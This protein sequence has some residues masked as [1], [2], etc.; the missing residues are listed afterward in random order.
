VAKYTDDDFDPEPAVGKYTDDDFDRVTAEE[1]PPPPP[2]APLPPTAVSIARDALQQTPLNIAITGL[3]LGMAAPPMIKAAVEGITNLGRKAAEVGPP[4]SAREALDL[5][6]AAGGGYASGVKPG[7]KQFVGGYAAGVADLATRAGMEG[8]ARG[9][10]LSATSHLTSAAQDLKKTGVPQQ[11]EDVHS[12]TQFG[13]FIG[14]QAG[15][16][17]L[18]AAQSLAIG[19]LTRGRSLPASLAAQ[20]GSATLMEYGQIAQEANEKLG[21]GKVPFT[22]MAKGA[23][24][25]GALE[26]LGMLPELTLLRGGKGALR[27]AGAVLV[28]P[29]LEGITEAGQTYAEATPL[30]GTAAEKSPAQL[31][32][33]ARQAA[34][35]GFVASGPSTAVAAGLGKVKGVAQRE[36]ARPELLKQAREL[37]IPEPEKLK[38]SRLSEQVA[39][40]REQQYAETLEQHGLEEQDLVA[41]AAE[42]LRHLESLPERTP[43]Q[44]GVRQAL[45][46]ATGDPRKIAAIPGYAELVGQDVAVTTKRRE[47]VK[48]RVQA[49]DLLHVTEQDL[50]E[51]QSRIDAFE[52]FTAQAHDAAQAQLLRNELSAQQELL[53]VAEN[54]APELGEARRAVPPMAGGAMRERELPLR[55]AQRPVS[56]LTGPTARAQGERQLER[57]QEAEGLRELNPANHELPLGLPAPIE[58]AANEH[59]TAAVDQG[60][61][62][63]ATSPLNE[64]PIPTPERQKAGRYAKGLVKVQGMAISIEHPQGSTRYGVTKTGEEWQ[65]ELKDHYGYF[66][67]GKGKDGDQLDVFIGPRPISH[68]VFVVN[69]VDPSTGKFDEHKVMLGYGSVAEAEAAYQRNYQEGWQGLKSVTPMSMKEFKAWKAKSRHVAEVTNDQTYQP[70]IPSSEPQGPAAVEAGLVPAPSR[71]AARPSRDVQAPAGEKAA[72]VVATQPAATGKVAAAPSRP[73]KGAPA[74]PVASTRRGYNGV[75]Y[76]V[77]PEGKTKEAAEGL[78]VLAIAAEREGDVFRLALTDSRVKAAQAHPEV[79]TL[80]DKG[81]YG[82]D[83]VDVKD[84]STGKSLY[85][86]KV[87]QPRHA[88]AAKPHPGGLTE[89]TAKEIAKRHGLDRVPF[90]FID[91]PNFRNEQKRLIQGRVLNGEVLVN[92]AAIPDAQRLEEV[93]LEEGAHH[94][95]GSE[96]GRALLNKFVRDRLTL[97]ALQALQ[98]DYPRN[99]E[100]ETTEDYFQRIADEHIAQQ[101]E[102]QTPQWKVLVQVVKEFLARTGLVDLSDATASQAVLRAVRHESDSLAAGRGARHALVSTKAK[103]YQNIKYPEFSDLASGKRVKEISDKNMMF[104]SVRPLS[105]KTFVVVADGKG[106]NKVSPLA[107]ISQTKHAASLRGQ[108]GDIISHPE[109]FKNYP[110]LAK[111]PTLIF[112]DHKLPAHEWFGG[113]AEDVSLEADMRAASGKT[114]R[115]TGVEITAGSMKAALEALRHELTH[116]I[117]SDEGLPQGASR[118][119]MAQRKELQ[120]FGYQTDVKPE[121]EER[122]RSARAGEAYHRETGEIYARAVEKRGALSQEEL[123]HH[124]FFEDLDVPVSEEITLEPPPQYVARRTGKSLQQPVLQGDVGQNG[125]K[126]PR[127]ARHALAPRLVPEGVSAQ[128]DHLRSSALLAGEEAQKL[129]AEGKGYAAKNAAIRANQLLSDARREAARARFAVAPDEGQLQLPPSAPS[130]EDVRRGQA[131]FYRGVPEG[132]PDVPG[133]VT[134]AT[135]DKSFAETFH[136]G[137]AGTGKATVREVPVSGKN[138]WDFRDPHHLAAIAAPVEDRALLV[139]GDWGAVERNLELI[140]VAGYDGFTE[141]ES[142]ALN[143]GI[144]NFRK[145]ERPGEMA[146]TWDAESAIDNPLPPPEP[147]GGLT[148]SQ[149]AAKRRAEEA[150]TANARLALAPERQAKLDEVAAFQVRPIGELQAM[151]PEQLDRLHDYLTSREAAGTL[152]RGEGPVSAGRFALAKFNYAA[153]PKLNIDAATNDD[154]EFKTPKD[155]AAFNKLIKSHLA[156]AKGAKRD[157]S[158]IVQNW[159]N[160]FG[161]TTKA[162]QLK[163][164]LPDGVWLGGAEDTLHDFIAGNQRHGLDDLMRAGGIRAWMTPSEASFQIGASLTAEQRHQIAKVISEQGATA[165]KA[166]NFRMF[167][168]VIDPADKKVNGMKFLEDI[169][170]EYFPASAEA[171]LTHVDELVNAVFSGGSVARY[172]SLLAPYVR[173]WGSDEEGRFALAPEGPLETLT[174]EETAQRFGP[175]MDALLAQDRET[176]EQFIGEL[177]DVSAGNLLHNVNNKITAYARRAAPDLRTAMDQAR[178]A[179]ELL[180]D[181]L[182][183]QGRFALAPTYHSRLQRAVEG[184]KSEKISL[185]ELTSKTLVNVDAEERKWSGFDEWVTEQRRQDKRSVTKSEVL[186]F[187]RENDVR[188]EEKVLTNQGSQ[189]TSLRDAARDA[190]AE[191][192]RADNDALR[193]EDPSIPDVFVDPGDFSEAEVDAFLA[194]HGTE[195]ENEYEVSET[196]AKFASYQLPGGENYRELLLTLPKKESDQ[197]TSLAQELRAAEQKKQAILGAHPTIIDRPNAAIEA[198]NDIRDQIG[199]IQQH[200][201]DENKTGEVFISSHF[202]EPNILAHVRFNERTDT[203]GKRVLFLEELQSDWAQTGRKKGFRDERATRQ[204]SE[205]SREELLEL[206]QQNDRNGAYTDEATAAEDL[207]PMTK[208]DALAVF[209]EFQD[210]DPTI[211]AGYFLRTRFSADGVPTAPFVQSTEKWAGLALRRMV[212]WAA[213]HG[214]ERLAWTTG[215]QQAERYDL[216][217]V[218]DDVSWSDVPRGRAVDMKLRGK[219]VVGV[220]I[221]AHGKIVEGVSEAR[222]LVGRSIDEVVGKDIAAKIMAKDIGRLGVN[223]LKVGGEGMKGFYDLVLPKLAAKIGK[224]WGARVGEAKITQGPKED[225]FLEVRIRSAART[226]GELQVAVGDG[227]FYSTSVDRIQMELGYGDQPIVVSAARRILDEGGGT[228]IKIPNPNYQARTTTTIH[229]LDLP[230]TMRESALREGVA[231][232]ALAPEDSSPA[233]LDS[234]DWLTRAEGFRLP[235]AREA[236]ATAPPD[237]TPPQRQAL[238]TE[239]LLRGLAAEGSWLGGALKGVLPSALSPAHLQAAEYVGTKLG[240]R[241]HTAEQR[242]PV[243]EP[244]WQ[245]FTKLGVDKEGPLEEN[246]GIQF[247]SALSSPA[248]RFTVP[249]RL[250][251]AATTIQRQFEQAVKRVIEVE[252]LAFQAEDGT[253]VVRERY[254]PGMYTKESK[255]AFNQAMAEHV[256]AAR[257]ESP[258][259]ELADLNSWSAEERAELKARVEELLASG[260]GRQDDAAFARAF[261]RRPLEGKKSFLKE[262]VFDDIMTAVDFGLRPFSNNPV[263]LVAAKLHELDQFVLGRTIR[264]EKG[265]FVSSFKTA[266]APSG[267]RVPLDPAFTVIGPPQDGRPV[268]GHYYVPNALADV[269]DNFMSPT[270]Y[271][272]ANPFISKSYQVYMKAGARL[273]SSQL[274]VGSFFHAGFTS[275]ESIISALAAALQDTYQAATGDLGAAELAKSWAALPVSIA[276]IPNLMA[277]GKILEAWRSETPEGKHLKDVVRAIELAGG[278]FEL[279][280]GLMTGDTKEMQRAW[281][282]GRPL[283]AAAKVPFAAIEGLANLIM[284]YLV[285][286]QKAHVFAELASRIMRDHPGAALETLTPQF[287]QAWNRVDARL[288]QVRYQRLFMDNTVKSVVQGLIRAPGWTGGTIAEVGGSLKDAAGFA[289]ELAQGRWPKVLPARIAYTVALLTATAVMNGALT[290]LFTGDDP[291]DVDFWAFRTGGFD[292]KGRPERFLLP[293]YAKDIH[294]YVADAKRGT[295]LQTLSHKVHP[296]ITLIQ[297]AAS[298][299]TYYGEEVRH[300]GDNVFQQ[301]LDVGLHSLKEFE[302]FWTRGARREYQRQGDEPTTA[303]SVAKLAAPQFGI[304]PAPTDYTKT[305]A[306]K[307]L[308]QV[309]DRSSLRPLTRKQAERRNLKAEVRRELYVRKN[310]EPLREAIAAGKLTMAEA[311]E[312]RKTMNEPPLVHS[313]QQQG[314][315][316]NDIF[317]IYQ[318]ATAKE[319]AEIRPVVYRRFKNALHSALPDDRQP[320]ID[321]YRAVIGE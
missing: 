87:E 237:R 279:E 267:W 278:G 69:Q 72:P 35:A 202:D 58:E 171:A 206:L 141:V 315:T 1:A 121:H 297:T 198:L 290:K 193:E 151:A 248:S 188:V 301:L 250:K 112:L 101:F 172:Q 67:T 136:Q 143:V 182:G 108:L 167:I 50:Q 22:K 246:D 132:V 306:E 164:L 221:D 33:E 299:K 144:F 14:Q 292:E 185:G 117:A 265:Q 19:Y 218:V 176:A 291:E 82:V 6:A 199:A 90:Q 159:I 157:V 98:K 129:Q 111:L 124:P 209:Q 313:I 93:I 318:V 320:L 39:L 66:D 283:T 16:Q 37:G 77:L 214:F 41:R 262:K 169:S 190:M 25:A 102:G 178:R 137:Y 148:P 147:P 145:G 32:K 7:A 24:T 217:K 135:S 201:R 263:D 175:L 118:D 43:G 52:A 61:H 71:K 253:Y 249:D 260:E 213:E 284:Q 194:E 211:D 183:D 271:Q 168:D 105:G 113:T 303:A 269:L 123:G 9:L 17:T 238:R 177:R 11:L 142:G 21:P 92:L 109:L 115:T 227:M 288:G 53:P 212:R 216:S 56:A 30:K 309:V 179:G 97:A 187:L 28:D 224:P 79:F 106:A 55:G 8:A 219:L 311:R 110:W 3:K 122:L 305:R 103:D 126:L 254:F 277:G 239:G 107:A 215:E 153:A 46:T 99:A 307:L 210:A 257:E 258:D 48:N 68:T 232:F 282:G 195:L 270:L 222:G 191:E 64:K 104:Q 119:V 96:K 281:H 161:T 204:L 205:L 189:A 49:L 229:A 125:R 234:D 59:L 57:A 319:Q 12:L 245:A 247:M 236:V 256:E 60:A 76:P 223:D 31:A 196:A 266:Q 203:E 310:A 149:R 314:V 10:D 85:G 273:N 27:K 316:I 86:Q 83:V 158:A 38:R 13:A 285:P 70:E 116:A 261:S 62:E 42:H 36:L 274:G 304:M 18:N 78:A 134:Y 128:Y 23:A 276:V 131:V 4:R 156:F 294:A 140:K 286:R 163:V 170:R 231:K 44:E 45:A 180:R 81:K 268:L 235:A 302:P 73:E 152:R 296:L 26:G 317:A 280:R 160:L 242:R 186:A 20:I 197:N 146:S 139:R 184:I 114:V 289:Q 225:P 91:D 155:E 162:S 127:P 29:G 241:S 130:V 244:F 54:V 321:Q 181:L 84:P 95:L 5:A 89:A 120:R 34:V 208:D 166:G 251:P 94:M 15:L 200:M 252:P 275:G 220:L 174:P 138:L 65:T 165:I 226:A 264:R 233:S 40:Y 75:T 255:A 63:A 293:T 228:I 192:A 287:R 207:D 47:D 173:P 100:E 300:K 154:G 150:R 312:M 240:E 74:P 298:N 243:L 80:E 308:D 230:P 88:L 259:F 272:H 51:Y 295:P 133:H 2:A